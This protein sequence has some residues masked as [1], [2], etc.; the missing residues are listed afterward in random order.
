MPTSFFECFVFDS[1]IAMWSL[2]V[3]RQSLAAHATAHESYAL[4]T[5]DP[6]L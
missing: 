5:I 1:L 6:L 3:R 2:R 4:T